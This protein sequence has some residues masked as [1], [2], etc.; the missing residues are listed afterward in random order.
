MNSNS[1]T[2]AT[3]LLIVLGV[4]ALFLVSYFSFRLTHANPLI[5]EGLIAQTQPDEHGTLTSEVGR[6]LLSLLADLRAISFRTDFMR[7]PGFLRLEDFS[8][9]LEPQTP[10]RENPFAPIE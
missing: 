5:G 2:T 7:E 6:E 8:R 10:G 1:K 9:P 3:I 4:S